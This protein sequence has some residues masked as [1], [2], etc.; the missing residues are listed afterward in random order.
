MKGAKNLRL[1]QEILVLT[2]NL[3]HDPEENIPWVFQLLTNHP[4]FCFIHIL[5]HI[6]AADLA[7]T[8]SMRIWRGIMEIQLVHCNSST[9]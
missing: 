3:K 1:I 4:Q 5:Y 9:F 6:A 7:Y 8:K 2:L